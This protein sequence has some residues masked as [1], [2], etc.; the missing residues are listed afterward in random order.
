[1]MA[2]SLKAYIREGISPSKL[3][4]KDRPLNVENKSLKIPSWIRRYGIHGFLEAYS[5]GS[6]KQVSLGLDNQR[7][8][9]WWKKI[10][11]DPAKFSSRVK[12]IDEFSLKDKTKN[13]YELEW[14]FSIASSSALFKKEPLKEKNGFSLNAIK[15]DLTKAKLIFNYQA[16]KYQKSLMVMH[17]NLDY[18]DSNWVTRKMIKKNPLTNHALNAMGAYIILKSLNAGN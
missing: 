11:N 6:L 4:F 14:D 8:V 3:K 7:E 1:M 5:D 17:C 9:N 18:S 13:L 16:S 15:G 10:L 2:F 12:M